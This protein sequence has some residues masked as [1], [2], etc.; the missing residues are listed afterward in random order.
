MCLRNMS[1]ACK[2]NKLVWIGDCPKYT[3]GLTAIRTWK[4]AILSNNS[5]VDLEPK[6]QSN[7]NISVLRFSSRPAENERGY[8]I[9]A[10]FGSTA[11]LEMSEQ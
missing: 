4:C 7:H 2:P 9:G 1:M 3:R 11:D 6:Q 8:V 10:I 5:N